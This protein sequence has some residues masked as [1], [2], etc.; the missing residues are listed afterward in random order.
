MK[1]SMPITN[2]PESCFKGIKM[3]D[4][5]VVPTTGLII[6]MLNKPNPRDS[7]D[8][9]YSYLSSLYLYNPFNGHTSTYT[10]F[11]LL[12][13]GLA[14][15]PNGT[16]LV[17][18]A[19]YNSFWK[20]S[21]NTVNA[22][23]SS[24]SFHTYSHNGNSS[25]EVE[26]KENNWY[27]TKTKCWANLSG[28]IVLDNE[29]L[30]IPA[31][32]NC[33]YVPPTLYRYNNDETIIKKK[34]YFPFLAELNATQFIAG[35]QESLCLLSKDDL[36]RLQK[37]SISKPLCGLI[38]SSETQ[39][40]SAHTNQHGHGY[41]RI[42]QSVENSKFKKK[43]T[44]KLKD[45]PISNIVY[46][47]TWSSVIGFIKFT[48][49]YFTFCTHTYQLSYYTA[50]NPINNMTCNEDKLIF[51]TDDGLQWINLQPPKKFI[52]DSLLNMRHNLPTC[53][54]NV[55]YE[56]FS[57]EKSILSTT[58]FSSNKLELEYINDK[59]KKEIENSNNIFCVSSR[60]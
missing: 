21:I 59:E 46:N 15:S 49:R 38:S 3:T 18:A 23:I 9:P 31:N 12:R 43:L 56:Y 32:A 19:P 42:Y 16:H 25:V 24:T 47:K 4:A 8:D 27:Y 13:G 40:I 53:L 35:N 37:I 60:K 29:S 52:L 50:K 10:N 2:P 28:A 7:R 33:R 39:F 1:E 55:I 54:T 45:F 36:H 30:I 51:A 6:G 41:L 14:F 5:Y 58:F 57:E 48:N 20:W 34:G 44:V 11:H 26:D 17:C 22:T